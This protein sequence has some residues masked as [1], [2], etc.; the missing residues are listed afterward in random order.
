MPQTKRKTRRSTDKVTPDSSGVDG[1]NGTDNCEI[2]SSDAKK[3]KID[4]DTVI[5]G[6]NSTTN[7]DNSVNSNVD[8]SNGGDLNSKVEEDDKPKQ[9]NGDQT[10]D[11]EDS[12]KTDCDEDHKEAVA[13]SDPIS[14]V[15]NNNNGTSKSSEES[16]KGGKSDLKCE[17]GNN[18]H[19]NQDDNKVADGDVESSVQSASNNAQEQEQK[20]EKEKDPCGSLVLCGG[21]SWDLTGRKELPK[22]AKNIP[23]Q[24]K[25][26]WGP[27]VWRENTR[28]REIISSCTACHSVI[29]TENG[30]ALV[31]GRNDKGQLGLG[32]LV[33]RHEPTVVETLKNLKI[34]SA[35]TGKGHTLFL[36]EE[37]VV[38]AAGDNKMGQLG[39]GSQSNNAVLVPTKIAYSGKPVAKVACG[40]EF[41][42]MVDAAGTLYSF[43]SPEYGQLGHN[44]EGKYF[45][46]GNKISYHCELSPRRVVVF[47]EKTREGH[48]I[49]LEDVRITGIAA[50]INHCL[51]MDSKKRV[52]T[53]GFA[54]YG[55]LGHNET[56][57]EL[58]PRNLKLFDYVNRGVN[59]VWAGGCFS[60]ALDMNGV[61][62]FWGQTK[63]SGEATMYPKPIQDLCNWNIRSVGCANRSIV[64]A[65][66]ESLISW[67]PSPTYGEL[68]YGENKAKSSTTPQEVKI[69]EKIFI[70]KVTCG[71]G[72]TLM[73]A[74]ET[75]VAKLP[76]WP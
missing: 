73:I 5:D 61:L 66:D 23:Q 54:G 22:A 19:S 34:K 4:R 2:L 17:S 39:I 11:K 20:K 24:G 25:N 59:N 51:A 55:R 38:Y 29:I 18:N 52:F 32:D 74:D 10:E 12:K 43:G 47:I 49:P 36:T 45:T 56:K 67:G 64:I 70:K 14:D 9:K 50:G 65:A 33:T 31:F 26:L 44:S 60:L 13:S 15:T 3:C 57:D 69:L 6:K 48:V 30:K 1:D 16:E 76:K 42:L 58:V 28:I 40:A 75:N 62:Y 63:T 7:D 68:G 72:H 8:A 71:Y 21:T 37:G 27:H 46:T 41:S 53:W 35:A